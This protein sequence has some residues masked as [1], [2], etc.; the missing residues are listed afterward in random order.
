MTVAH[1][2]PMKRAAM[3]WVTEQ[4]ARDVLRFGKNGDESLKSD[5][6]LAN[7]D[8]L[9]EIA[10]LRG[11]RRTM[12][13]ASPVGESKSNGVVERAIQSMAKMIGF[14]KLSI[15]TRINEK[16]SVRQLLFA[17]LVEFCADL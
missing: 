1:V 14:H 9:K 15:E 7:E 10:K 6:E 11:P 17:C 3:E 16:L 2:V 4:A 13:E 5:Q 12:L 8:V